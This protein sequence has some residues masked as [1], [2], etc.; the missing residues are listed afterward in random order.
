MMRISSIILPITLLAA[1]IVNGAQLSGTGIPLAKRATGT[2]QY[3]LHDRSV[4][5]LD[6]PSPNQCFNIPETDAQWPANS[7][8]N[9][10]DG[11]ATVFLDFDC[12]GDTYYVLSPGK[13]LKFRSVVFS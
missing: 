12:E 5:E 10:L 1:G 4:H 6:H 2:F 13:K 9:H 3:R 7:P 8:V 11:T